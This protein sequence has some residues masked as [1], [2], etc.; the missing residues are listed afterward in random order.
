LLY[1]GQMDNVIG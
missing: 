1:L